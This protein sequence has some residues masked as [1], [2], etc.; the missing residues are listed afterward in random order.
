MTDTEAVQVGMST[1]VRKDYVVS[2]DFRA[3]L[4]PGVPSSRST[5]ITCAVGMAAVELFS[6]WEPHKVM[7][8]LGWTW[9]T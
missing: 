6:E 2:V 9:L 1:W 8:A 7:K 5:V 4:T 3:S